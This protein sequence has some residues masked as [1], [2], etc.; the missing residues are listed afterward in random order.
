M[1]EGF[2]V[3]WSNPGVMDYA[4]TF[5]LQIRLSRK[6]RHQPDLSGCLLLL[7]H[8]HN[9]TFGY[10]LKYDQARSQLRVSAD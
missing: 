9:I 3:A 2:K 7:E 10:S 1:I 4:E 8:P 6:L 5:E